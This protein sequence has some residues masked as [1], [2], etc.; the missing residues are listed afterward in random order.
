MSL[1]SISLKLHAYERKSRVVKVPKEERHWKEV[2]P[3]MMSDEERVGDK[4]VRHPPSFRSEK[5][6]KFI[7][8]LDSRLVKKGVNA[9][10]F[11]SCSGFPK[12]FTITI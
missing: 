6:S 5:V 4:Y 1:A 9:N 3:E 8:K 11:G 2:T 7:E 10:S 12:K